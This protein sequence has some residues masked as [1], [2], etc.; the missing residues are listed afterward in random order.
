MSYDLS[1]IVAIVIA[2][3]SSTSTASRSTSTALLS[4]IRTVRLKPLSV[5]S[6]LALY[7]VVRKTQTARVP[8]SHLPAPSPPLGVE[9]ELRKVGAPLEA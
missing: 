5:S 9:G 1:I 2:V 8:P 6:L 3:G 7:Y 4:T